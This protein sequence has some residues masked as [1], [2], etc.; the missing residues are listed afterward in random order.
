MNLLAS[1]GEK[2]EELGS[3][4]DVTAGIEELVTHNISLAVVRP[5]VPAVQIQANRSIKSI[6]RTTTSSHST[7]VIP[8]NV[9]G[10]R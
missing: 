3:N 8:V 4:N 9:K 10:N 6:E 1:I 7:R 5:A 2:N